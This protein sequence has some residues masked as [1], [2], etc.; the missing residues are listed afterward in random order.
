ME[1]IALRDGESWIKQ[2]YLFAAPA[3]AADGTPAPFEAAD[4]RRVSLLESLL[5]TSVL[6]VPPVG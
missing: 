1:R 5:P 3:R 2:L 4:V 6:A